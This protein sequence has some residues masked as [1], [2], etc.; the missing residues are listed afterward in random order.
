MSIHFSLNAID[1]IARYEGE[2]EGRKRKEMWT[3]IGFRDQR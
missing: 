2:R 3:Q 1:I